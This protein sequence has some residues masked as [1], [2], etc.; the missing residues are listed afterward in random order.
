MSVNIN[1]A[2]LIAVILFFRLRSPSDKTRSPGSVQLTAAL[3]LI[4][5]VLLVGTKT[6]EILLAGIQGVVTML[7]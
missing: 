5:G 2:V 7:G 3:A 6:G 1:V 4:L